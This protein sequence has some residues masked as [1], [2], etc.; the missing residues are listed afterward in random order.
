MQVVTYDAG[1]SE[2]RPACTLNPLLGVR[3]GAPSVRLS[4]SCGQ[5]RESLKSNSPLLR[6]WR[7]ERRGCR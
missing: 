4:P 5:L 2:K 6:H 1:S 3:L 7:C